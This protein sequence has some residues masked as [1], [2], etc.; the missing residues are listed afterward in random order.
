VG[1]ALKSPWIDV[2]YAHVTAA[3]ISSSF[4]GAL[5]FQSLAIVFLRERDGGRED[6]SHRNSL[7]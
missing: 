3:M 7:L 6:E 2:F 4:Q 5:L 1:G